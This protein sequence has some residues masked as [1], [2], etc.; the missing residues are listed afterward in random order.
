M[1]RMSLNKS[2]ALLLV[3]VL[4]T[5][6]II[7]FLS[8]NADSRTIVVSDHYPAITTAIPIAASG[9]IVYVKA[10]TY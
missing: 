7:T 9:D 8:V 3:F 2:V 1:M 4:A 10:G 5:S 6:S